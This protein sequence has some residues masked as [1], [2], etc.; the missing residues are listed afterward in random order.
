MA[1]PR[2]HVRSGGPFRL[3]RLCEIG[4]AKLADPE[5]AGQLISDVAALEEAGPDEIS[6]LDN[7]KYQD[8]FSRSRAGACIVHADMVGRAPGGMALLV[9]AQP[10]LG[11]ARI[12]RAFYPGRP[13]SGRID[14][15]A[16]VHPT[17][18]L[19]GSVEVGA[20]AVIGEGV[21]IG[22]RTVI[23]PN[24]VVDRNVEI[25]ADC[26]IGANASLSH[27]L[28]ADRCQL[29]PGV[30]I[31]NRGFGFAMSPDGHEDVPQLGRVIIE[32]GVEVGANS[33]IDRGAGPDTVIGA[34]TRIDNLVQI[35]HNV[36]TGRG[37]VIV[38]QSGISGSTQLE[39]FVLVAA[40]AGLTGHLKIG[41]GARIGA[42]SGV[43]RDVAPA[44]EVFGSPAKLKR[45]AFRE[46]VALTKLAAKRD[47]G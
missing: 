39:D 34:G 29:H 27:C 28:I 17:A 2:F 32:E 41:Q 16:L 19:D 18:V 33:T 45:D 21:R 31:G 10:Y 22:A 12:A 40:Q 23:G 47:K 4:A 37:C 6:F 46:L 13:A 3:D 11:Y 36:R 20:G 7:P 15:A 43:M 24:T 42:Q 35:G 25:G 44:T 1:D 38:A 14:P 26:V 5:Q 9:S 30:C 8:A